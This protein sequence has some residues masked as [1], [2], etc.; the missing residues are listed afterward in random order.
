MYS[1]LIFGESLPLV[2]L[3]TKNKHGFVEDKEASD[4][5]ISLAIR[6]IIF[7]VQLRG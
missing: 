1:L 6:R 5:F 4:A 3:F 7:A 2:R